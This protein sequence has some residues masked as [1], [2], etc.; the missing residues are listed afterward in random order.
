MD[1]STVNK[2]IANNPGKTEWDYRND[3]SNY[4]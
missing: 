4:Q 1:D 2:W 3:L